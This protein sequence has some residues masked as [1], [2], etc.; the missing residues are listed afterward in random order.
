MLANPRSRRLWQAVAGLVT[1]IAAGSAIPPAAAQVATAAPGTARFWFYRDF[2][3]NDTGDM[4]AVAMNGTTIGYGLSGTNFYRD[5]PASRY[6]LTVES[7]GQ[8][9]GQARDVTVAPGQL[10]YVKI[11]SL[12]SWEEGG[13]RGGY[14]RG[15]YYVMIVPPQLAALEISTTT[16][17]TPGN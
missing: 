7:V 6:H 3:A 11:A 13:N 8:D 2:F 5:V 17:S 9:V 14:R 15:T 10:V 4:P 16:Y 1:L 12:P